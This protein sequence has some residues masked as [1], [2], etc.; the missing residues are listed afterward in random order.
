MLGI[1]GRKP[2]SPVASPA[3]TIVGGAGSSNA[4]CCNV[5]FV[6]ERVRVAGFA[7]AGGNC[8]L[9]AGRC[10]FLAVRVTERVVLSVILA[11]I[12][13]LSR[14]SMAITTSGRL[15]VAP[16]AVCCAVAVGVPISPPVI[17]YFGPLD[18]P[19]AALCVH[20]VAAWLG[21]LAVLVAFGPWGAI[22]S[23]IVTLF[24]VFC[25]AISAKT[26]VPFTLFGTFGIRSVVLT[27]VAFL[28]RLDN[29]VATGVS[30][31]ILGA[32]GRARLPISSV[33]KVPKIALLS[34]RIIHDSIT[35]VA[36]ELTLFC[37]S[38]VIFTIVPSSVTFFSI[39]FNSVSTNWRTLAFVGTPA[40]PDSI[41]RAKVTRFSV[42]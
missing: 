29:T 9:G 37:A 10:A 11:I 19:I 26:C 20:W 8:M 18:N 4:R 15:L 34:L 16:G 23:S 25:N 3:S 22:P 13:L 38:A 1:G 31:N 35:A 21:P 36:A 28:T 5:A 14:I 6:V 33:Q 7:W 24:W 40:V 41:L 27:I 12:A 2:V 42:L 30:A 39:L 17:A 32:I